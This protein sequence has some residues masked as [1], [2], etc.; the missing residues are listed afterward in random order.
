[1][2]D[3]LTMDSGALIFATLADVYLS[4]GMIDEAISILKDGLSRNPTYT[5]AKIILGRAYYMKGAIQESIKV[6]EEVYSEVKDSENTNLYL[7]HCYK[8]VGD[9]NKAADFY[10]NTLQINPDNKEAQQELQTLQIEIGTPPT[11]VQPVQETAPAVA[12][13]EEIEPVAAVP[14]AEIPVT[15][16]SV[17]VPAV[18]EEEEP[19]QTGEPLQP[20]EPAGTGSDRNGAAEESQVPVEAQFSQTAEGAEE[21]T[22]E[23]DTEGVDK[24]LSEVPVADQQQEYGQVVEPETIEE[25]G[26]PDKGETDEP[27]VA[28]LEPVEEPAPG[29]ELST[30]PVSATVQETEG[31]PRVQAIPPEDGHG[32]LQAEPV[33]SPAETVKVDSE[34]TTENEI[35]DRPTTSEVVIP[36]ETLNEPMNK[37][38]AMKNVK[39]AFVC[40]P[41]GLMIQ[42]YYHDYPDIE[43]LCAM[44]AAIHNDAAEAFRF[45]DE[46]DVEKFII[47]KGDETVCAITAGESLLTVIT[48]AE[49]KPG[50][51]FIYAR[52]VIEEIREILG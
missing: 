25:K 29:A 20:E 4:S 30:E 26:P 22:E 24:P 39:G 36:F 23:R 38:L 21:I 14:V 1:M 12:R 49:A 28:V 45:L 51:V 31:T 46:G 16:E 6:L 47:E 52:K 43:E 27:A 35:V 37:L 2:S 44:V 34:T 13:D 5:L 32:A 48:K 15:Q 18:A 19:G 41:D 42:N 40:S 50:L 33:P 7:G 17:N 10:K 9:K 8:K 3:E 11:P